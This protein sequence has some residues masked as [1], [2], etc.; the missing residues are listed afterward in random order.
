MASGDDCLY[1]WMADKIIEQKKSCKHLSKVS[2]HRP[3]QGSA[4]PGLHCELKHVPLMLAWINGLKDE[5]KEKWGNIHER[6]ETPMNFKEQ[7]EKRTEGKEREAMNE[8]SLNVEGKPNDGWQS[9]CKRKR[10][11]EWMREG[12]ANIRRRWKYQSRADKQRSWY[13]GWER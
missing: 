12:K 5:W 8:G 6:V 11:R 7:S 9:E 2:A 3:L 4:E 1:F 10:G 13:C